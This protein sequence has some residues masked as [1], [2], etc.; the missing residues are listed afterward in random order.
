MQNLARFGTWGSLLCLAARAFAQDEQA[1]P[2]SEPPERGAKVV[3]S[4]EFDAPGPSPPPPSP[5]PPREQRVAFGAAGQW[6]LLGSSTSLGVSGQEFSN[7]DARQF[8]VGGEVGFDAFVARNFSIGPDVEGGYTVRQGYSS[9]ALQ[10][11]TEASV[12]IGARFG[13]NVPLSA[14]F[15]WFPRLTVGVEWTHETL[16]TIGYLGLE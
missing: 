12:S 11:G 8:N 1:L 16:Q 3:D 6:A 13:V 2:E 10:K 4:I 9:T 15:S 14:A 7:S 5:A